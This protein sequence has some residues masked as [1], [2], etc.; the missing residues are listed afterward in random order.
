M[1][2]N[3][4]QN[5]STSILPPEDRFPSELEVLEAANS[6]KGGINV[7]NNWFLKL[8]LESLEYKV[9]FVGGKLHLPLSSAP[10]RIG[11]H[12]AIVV[13]DLEKNG[14]LHLV[15]VGSGSPVFKAVPLNR[16]PYTATDVNLTY[17]FVEESGQW[18]NEHKV[19]L[20]HF[21]KR[22]FLILLHFDDRLSSVN[23]K[24]V[25]AGSDFRPTI[26]LQ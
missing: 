24:T 3:S 25:I 23:R 16:L 12:F 7:H 11:S 17:R 15:D 9:Y 20:K 10:R 1:K 5:I 19:S 21:L 2:K 26:K 6:L 14:D 18:H 8:L 4:L 13:R 22:I